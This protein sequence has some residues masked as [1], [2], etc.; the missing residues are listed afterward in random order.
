MNIIDFLPMVIT[1]TALI[2]NIIIGISNGISFTSLMIRCMVVTIVFGVFSHL[3]TQTIQNALECSS[4]SKHANE[5]SRE[6]LALGDTPG[7]SRN[8]S[9]FDIKVPPIDDEEL[10]SMDADVDD[11]FVEVNPVQMSG[12]ITEEQD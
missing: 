7:E 10:M 8:K 2:A 9:T 12:L 11:E 5:K 4:L 3:L 6:G 1:I